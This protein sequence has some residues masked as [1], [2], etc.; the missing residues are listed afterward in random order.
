MIFPKVCKWCGEEFIAKAGSAKYCSDICRT[1]ALREQKATYT[2]NRRKELKERGEIIRECK[3][4]GRDFKPFQAQKYCCPSCRDAATGIPTVIIKRKKKTSPKM[5]LAQVAK[6]AA[7]AGM[8]Y[9]EYVRKMEV[10]G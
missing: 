6:A 2:R 4:C 9:G 3:W 7:A 1:S 5:S 8:T 10:A